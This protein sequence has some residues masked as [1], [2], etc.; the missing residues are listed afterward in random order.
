MSL[1]TITDGVIAAGALVVATSGVVQTFWCRM[2][3]GRAIAPNAMLSREHEPLLPGFFAFAGSLLVAF[4][5]LRGVPIVLPEASLPVVFL[6]A[7][8][9]VLRA[10]AE[11]LARIIW[12]V[13]EKT[14]RFARQGQYAVFVGGAVLVALVAYVRYTPLRA[15]HLQWPVSGS[16]KVVAGG[17][18]AFANPHVNNPPSQSYAVDLLKEGDPNASEGQPV[19]SPCSGMVVHAVGDRPE[20]EEE[21]AEG[22]EVVVQLDD[23]TLVHLA[24][25]QQGSVRVHEGQVLSD[26]QPLGRC[27]ATGSAERAHLHVHAERNGRAVPMGFGPR[28]EYLL[29]GDHIDADPLVEKF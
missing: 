20:G 17:R 14:S 6:L 18:L 7:C 13:R 21:P 22:N 23:G 27:G 10:A 2:R 8:T 16:W 4:A 15:V 11:F 5:L 28:N 3:H 29:R 19:W 26:G 24:H 9:V 12:P 25:L 1:L